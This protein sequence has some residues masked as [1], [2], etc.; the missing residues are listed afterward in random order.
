MHVGVHVHAEPLRCPEQVQFAPGANPCSHCNLHVRVSAHSLA[1]VMGGAA[2]HDP[3]SLL[4][5]EAPTPLAPATK[6]M[7]CA[8]SG[9]HRQL[10]PKQVH[11]TT[12]EYFPRHT[13]GHTAPET[14]APQVRLWRMRPRS[15]CGNCCKAGHLR[16]LVRSTFV[17][18]SKLLGPAS[19]APATVPCAL[20]PLT[21]S[22]ISGKL[23]VPCHISPHKP[24]SMHA[25]SSPTV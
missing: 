5:I 15:V 6:A 19:S 2:A 4:F 9:I 21:P 12:G 16:K 3:T 13:S 11:A 25:P 1:W 10:V 18:T 7:L 14:Y 22:E 23:Q 8:Q 24:A 17:V 20:Q